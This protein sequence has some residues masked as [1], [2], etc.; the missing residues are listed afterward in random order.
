MQQILRQITIMCHLSRR[1]TKAMP[2]SEPNQ[3][4]ASPGPSLRGSHE[5][6]PTGNI[7]KMFERAAMA[8]KIRWRAGL[9]I[10][11]R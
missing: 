1:H 8:S 4:E 10:T 6:D 9:A 7:G 11:R 5:P 3:L 2:N